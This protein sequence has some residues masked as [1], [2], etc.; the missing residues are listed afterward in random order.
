MKLSVN[1]ATVEKYN[2]NNR[3]KNVG[4]CVKRAMSLA[5]DTPYSEISKLLNAKMKELRKTKW[6]SLKVFVPVM[7]ELGA[8]GKTNM[9]GDPITLEEWVDQEAD[10][11]KTYI[12]LVG[13]KPGWTDHLV[14]VRDGKIWDS[15]DSRGRYITTYWVVKDS[16]SHKEFTDIKDHLVHS[17]LLILFCTA[18][19]KNR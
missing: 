18:S 14:C 10:P 8:T 16:V 11:N 17:T 3:G 2:A 1:S 19:S 5:F 15:W 9:S 7:E 4:D 13:K 12:L 6:N